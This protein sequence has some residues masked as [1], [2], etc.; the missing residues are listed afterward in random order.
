MESCSRVPAFAL[1]ASE[2][3]IEFQWS[4]VHASLHL[5]QV[6]S[7]VVEI[8]VATCSQLPGSHWPAPELPKDDPKARPH[9]RRLVASGSVETS[10]NDFPLLGGARRG[11]DL[12]IGLMPQQMSGTVTGNS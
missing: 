1:C 11:T 8:G 10:G 2:L 7:W 6:I 4:R 3:I 12:K 9:P 5:A